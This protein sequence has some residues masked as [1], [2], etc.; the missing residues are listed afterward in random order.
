[1][2]I[3]NTN[4][5]F[6]H[7][8]KHD[9]EFQI[10]AFSFLIIKSLV[11]FLI[12]AIIIGNKEFVYYDLVILPLVLF[13]FFVHRRIQMHM[14]VTSLLY[15]IFIMHAAGGVMH[16]AGTRLYDIT[17]GI[18]K[19]DNI[20]HFLGSF[21][22]LLI[23]YGLFTHYVNRKGK[24]FNEF[25][26]FILL[27]LC[28]AGVGTLIEMVELIGVV[29]FDASEGVGNYMNNAIDLFVNLLGAIAAGIFVLRYRRRK[30]FKKLID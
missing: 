5:G 4:A 2:K 1:M 17:F 22:T 6:F 11:I 23:V 20:V 14:L 30:L 15:V 8:L 27:V 28:S 7:R 10:K 16:I 9:E 25:Y 26:L 3:K 18:I 12:T 29:F 13:V 21:V 19:F 24:R